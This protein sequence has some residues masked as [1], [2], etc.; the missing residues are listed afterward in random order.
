MYALFIA[1]SRS[2]RSML[3]LDVF[4]H[5]IWPG[6]VSALLWLAIAVFS[7][8]TLIGGIMQWVEGWGWGIGDQISASALLAGIVFFLVKFAVVCAFV[9]LFYVTSLA[10]VALVALPMMLD[11]VAQRDYADLEQ[12]RGGSNMGS[13][14][15]TITALLWFTL[16]FILSLPLWL[17][18]GVSLV[19][20][21]LA[22]GWLNQRVFSYDAL[23]RHADRDE[24][25]RLREKLRPSLLLLG[26]T[27]VLFAYV[28]LLNVIA[29]ALSGLAFVHFLLEA[30][31]R[32]RG[33]SLCGPEVASTLSGGQPV[34]I[35]AVG[36]SP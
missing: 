24:L 12:R 36:N 17:I 18:P 28:P 3:R 23:M 20:P 19:A 1:L 2:I 21:L 33:V 30:L 8:T 29:P 10:L 27:T 35:P 31:R 32:E 25:A 7:W 13:I 15:N 5:L 22:T 11:R 9:P 4:G 16:V 34:P 26:G 14:V 6:I